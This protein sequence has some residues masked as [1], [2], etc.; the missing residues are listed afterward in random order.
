[1]AATSRRST[2]TLMIVL[3]IVGLPLRFAIPNT[4]AFWRIF[5]VAF[6]IGALVVIVWGVVLL[7]SSRKTTTAPV[8]ATPPVSG[9]TPTPTDI[10]VTTEVSASSRANPADAFESRLDEAARDAIGRARSDIEEHGWHMV[11]VMGDGGDSA[12]I[13]TVGLME[14]Y[15]HPELIVFAPSQEPEG[16]SGPLTGIVERIAAGESF[17]ARTTHDGL[18]G[19]H[20][21]S[22]RKVAAENY[23]DYFGVAAGYY[24]N[25]DFPA[26]Q[27]F[28]P[29]PE[30]HFPWT[31]GCPFTIIMNQTMLVEDGDFGE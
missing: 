22:F 17:E 5:G 2:A 24:R 16:M 21:G 29:G 4:N 28:W 8:E 26:L 9:T 13:Y 25:F 12:F 23:E 18:F 7:V 14:T 15:G 6:A 11:G 27:V 3:G 20:P 19:R 10:D 1:M 30:G 31:E